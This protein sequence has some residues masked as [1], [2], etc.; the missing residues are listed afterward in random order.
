MKY[1]LIKAVTRMNLRKTHLFSRFISMLLVIGFLA[2]DLHAFDL[3]AAAGMEYD[4]SIE[5][6]L[7]LE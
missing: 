6:E 3:H 2:P 4:A 7:G 5:A 1:I